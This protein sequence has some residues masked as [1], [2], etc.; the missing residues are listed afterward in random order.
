MPSRLEDIIA[1]A[2]KRTIRTLL[3]EDMKKGFLMCHLVTYISLRDLDEEAPMQSFLTPTSFGHASF[4]NESALLKTKIQE[5]FPVSM[6][7]V[8]KRQITVMV[9]LTVDQPS[10]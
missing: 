2:A 1:N 8:K 6:M 10:F 3:M 9:H 5:N 7:H 4:R